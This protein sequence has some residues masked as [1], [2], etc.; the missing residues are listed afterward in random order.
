MTAQA[1][2][3]KE[4][5]T[6]VIKDEQLALAE[7]LLFVAGDPV[8]VET[9]AAV[10]AVTPEEAADVLQSLAARY[11]ADA[12]C[13][14]ELRETD[15]VW[16]L[17]TKAA[18]GERLKAVY[19]PPLTL[20]N[21]ALETLA[22]VAYQAP[23]TRARI[24]QLRGV[25]SERSIATL[26]ERDLIM[27]CGRAELPGRPI[28]YDVTPLFRRKTNGDAVTVAQTDEEGIRHEGTITETD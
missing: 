6:I 27:E 15:G 23:V 10:V 21:A 17:C 7:A 2:I 12:A 1:G 8:G 4:M 28:L 16:Q 25:G 14:I 11:V 5:M 20:S 18:Y 3:W 24:E 13:G 9:V 26:L 22:I 19:A